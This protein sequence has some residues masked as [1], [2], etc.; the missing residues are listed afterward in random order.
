ML[1]W[2]KQ[3]KKQKKQKFNAVLNKNHPPYIEAGDFILKKIGSLFLI[4]ALLISVPFSTEAGAGAFLVMDG[5]TQTVLEER[6]GELTLPMASTTK[7]MTALIV[8]E[9]VNLNEIVEIPQEAVGVE[10]T[11]LYIKKG[12]KYTVEELLYGLMLQSA[13]DCAEA[14]AW[15]AGKGNVSSFVDQMNAKAKSL[16]LKN[17]KFANPSGLP[18]K[19]HY[20]TAHELALIMF[21]AMKNQEFRKITAAAQ[22]KIHDKTIVNHNK[23]LK[24]YPN[25]IG[26][27]TGYTM[28]A[29]R[30]LVSVAER[31]GVS[32]ICVTLGIRDDWNIHTNAYEKW[33]GKTK[34][35]TL[36]EA[37]DFSVR[38]RV[39]GGGEGI[40][41]NCNKV[42]AKLFDA[43][44][45]V[46]KKVIAD[47][48]IYGNKESGDVV[49][50]VE[51]WCGPCKISESPLVLTEPIETEVKKDLFITGII[52]FFRRLLLKKE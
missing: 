12:E 30:C 2:S 33:F 39:A 3:A 17:T 29:G 18:D 49:G 13:N 37:G 26:G 43:E 22:Y 46:S 38:L 40:A 16:G 50:T 15:Y 45:N 35:R 27:K 25:C 19:E 4:L 51:Y 9:K 1:D 5:R 47:N 48:F 6:N 21:Y 20:T 10:G 28:A 23:L 42:C 34:E 44:K 14:L 11:S 41:T 36:D 8:L 52:R 24:L 32:L 7:I 31:R